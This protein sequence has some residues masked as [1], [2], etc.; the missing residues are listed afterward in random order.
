MRSVDSSARRR[1]APTVAL[2]GALALGGCAPEGKGQIKI[3]DRSKAEAGPAQ[4]KQDAAAKPGPGGANAPQVKSIKGRI[5][6]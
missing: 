2:L 1:L 4:P 6:Q 5:Q 3:G